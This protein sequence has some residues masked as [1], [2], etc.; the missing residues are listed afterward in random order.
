[1]DLVELGSVL[2]DFFD[3][4]AGP[5]HSELD[6][7]FASTQTAKFDP[8]PG[9]TSPQG[10]PLGKAKRIRQALVYASDANPADGLRF[11]KKVMAL[12]R[13]DGAF[14]GSATEP[15]QIARLRGAWSRLG[16]ALHSDGSLSP[17]VI[18]NLAGTEMTDALKAYVRRLN[19]NPDDA[20]LLVG[21]GKD[22]DEAAARHVL[23]E[24]VGSYET[25]GRGSSFPVT[26]AGAFT[27]TGLAMPPNVKL[28][29]DPHRA[30]QQ[31]LF[32]L[33]V[34][35]NRLRNEVGTGHGRPDVSSKTDVLTP[36][37][38]RLVARATA[39]I[40]GALLDQL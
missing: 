19:A 16:I 14:L 37:D 10:G 12:L 32:L 39:L 28:D 21:A 30:V 31:A 18:D 35:V 26:L 36:S 15:Q 40:A 9:G 11:A 13:A 24:L 20:A 33:G 34:Q 8:A 29:D 25:S 23:N 27:A 7:A 2:G 22:L 1:M 38:A 6:T 4:G 17:L 3:G 5:S